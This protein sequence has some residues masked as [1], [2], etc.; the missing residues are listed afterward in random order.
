MAVIHW[1]DMC[2][3]CYTKRRDCSVML[4]I[5]QRFSVILVNLIRHPL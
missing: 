2:G 4:D 1:L 3:N 5:H